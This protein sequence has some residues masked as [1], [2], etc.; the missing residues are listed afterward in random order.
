MPFFSPQSWYC[1]TASTRKFL[2]ISSVQIRNVVARGPS[3]CNGTLQMSIG[4]QGCVIQRHEILDAIAIA[5]RSEAAWHRELH[6][7]SEKQLMRSWLPVPDPGRTLFYNDRLGVM[8]PVMSVPWCLVAQSFGWARA[9][10][11]RRMISRSIHKRGAYHL[12]PS[13]VMFSLC[14]NL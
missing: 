7:Y 10:F 4:L 9:G 3:A 5:R 14:Y 6:T 1:T 12:S 13:S 11:T 8:S 2:A